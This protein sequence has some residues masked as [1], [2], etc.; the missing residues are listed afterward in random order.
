MKAN[1][2][3]EAIGHGINQENRLWSGVLDGIADGLGDMIRMPKR[4]WVAE[5]LG[6]H[7]KF[8]FERR[9]LSGKI[10]YKV[11]SSTA[12]RGVFLNYIL[13]TG[14]VYEVSQPTSWRSTSRFFATV[15]ESGEITEHRSYEDAKAA[16]ESECP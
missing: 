3:I 11:S 6:P 4:Y 13:E 12:N 8:K 2:K 9:F 10:D 16:I 14:R 1:L 7:P 15:S 5:I